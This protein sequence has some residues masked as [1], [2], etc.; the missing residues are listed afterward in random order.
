MY[1]GLK[2]INNRPAPFGHY[3]AADLWTDEHTS[4]KMLAFH[5]NGSI[6]VSS[7]KTGFID[8]SVAWMISAS[9]STKV[10]ASLTSGVDQG[11]TRHALPYRALP[12]PASTFPN[13]RFTTPEICHNVRACPSITSTATTWTLYRTSGST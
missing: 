6:D 4:S 12:S 5:L 10:R 8:Q 11:C 2:E 9:A 13:A 7:R 3:T 1:Q